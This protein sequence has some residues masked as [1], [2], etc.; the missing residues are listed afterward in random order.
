MGDR[1]GAYGVLLGEPERINHLEDLSLA[2]RII[3]KWI[4]EKWDGA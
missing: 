2:E 3:L 1:R 4:F